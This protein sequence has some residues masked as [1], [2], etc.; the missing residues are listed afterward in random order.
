M[1]I[2]SPVNMIEPYVESVTKALALIDELRG[3]GFDLDTIDIGGGFGADY[4]ENQAPL[5][6]DYAEAIVPLL[7]GRGLR[8][9]MEPGRSI[10]GNAGILLTRTQYVKS[11]GDKQFVIVDAAMNDLIRPS[12]YEAYHF[13]WPVRPGD[14]CVPDH[15]G[16]D[17]QTDEGVRVDV[18]GPICESGDFLG[19]NR[20]LPTVAR[21]DLLAV[22][23]AGAYGFTMS[24]QYNSR[25]RA[26]EVLVRGDDY[27]VIRRRETYADL[28]VGEE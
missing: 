8:V 26:A 4:H 13:I 27:R 5:S 21:D 16:Q 1:H 28:V 23:T 25:P 3:A 7:A 12:L 14:G 11:G 6:A 9:A 15:R 22:F 18:V 19:L 24:S 10:V 2:G 17:V 20:H